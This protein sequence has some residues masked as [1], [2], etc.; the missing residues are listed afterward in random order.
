M[1]NEI[2]AKPDETLIQHTENTLKVF[3]SIKDAYPEIPKL[4][5][6]NDFWEHLFYSLFFHDFGKAATG[7]QKSLFEKGSPWGYR[8]EILSSSFISSLNGFYSDFYKY[9]IGLAIIT[10]HKDVNFLR[11]HNFSTKP[12]GNKPSQGFIVY[13]KKLEELKINFNQL[14]KYFDLI[15]EFSDKYLGYQVKTPKT[16]KFNE[17]EDVFD[18]TVNKYYWGYTDD[19]Y[20]QLHRIYGVFL[21]GLVNACDYLASGS[22]YEILN[23]IK[24][25]GS[26]FDFKTLRKTQILASKTKGDTFLT[27]PTGSGK[28]EAALLWSGNNQNSLTS[29]RVFYLLPYTASINAMYTRLKKDFKNPNLVANLHGKASYFLYKTFS[30]LDYQ[31]SKDKVKEIQN[32]SKKIYRPYKVLTPFQIIKSF[33]GVKGFEMNLSELANSLIILDEIH[34]YDAHVTS[35]LLEIL[36]ILK[37]DYNVNFF[38]MS[39]TIPSFLKKIFIKELNINQ[40]ILLNN[41][42]LD[43]FNRHELNIINS[44]IMD[45]LDLIEEDLNQGLHVLVVCN[46]VNKAQKIY[47]HFKDKG[48]TNSALLHSRFIL[49]DRERIEGNLND[50]N[51]LVGTQAIEVSLNINYDTL[52]SEPAPLDAL[53]QRFGR[54]NRKGWEE[55]LIKKVNVF[56]TPSDNDKYIYNT[57]TVEKTL[58]VLENISLI[59]ESE[60]QKIIDAVYGEGYTGKDL[61]EFLSV[62]ENFNDFYQ[63]IV[64]FINSKDSE[65]SFYKLFNSY[66]IVPQKFKYDFTKKFEK[67]E[68]YEMKSYFVSISQGQFMKQLNE[69]NIE[70]DKT[71]NTYFIDIK[72]DSQLGLLLNEEEDQIL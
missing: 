12:I 30:N 56:S 49:K 54:V 6:V 36:K 21:K 33:F 35:L 58:K 9:S 53:I 61:D 19:E 28:T 65:S 14:I 68:Y 24:D 57:K 7:F 55:N 47:K 70:Y 67:K 60:I 31:E 63:T 15:P 26:L 32:L 11:E 3:K 18:L 66:E 2:F 39:A 69:N 8:H 22:K 72:Y 59:K 41:K 34:A 40:E 50:L 46:T 62:S 25:I 13:I 1:V 64:P 20:T 43:S 48:F 51:L 71:M 16:I 5:G 52:Y 37:K 10:H 27:A 4:C 42:E 29:K 38:I 45:N 17:L 23:G 44:N